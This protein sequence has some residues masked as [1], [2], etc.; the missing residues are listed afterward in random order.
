M[1][2]AG[3]ITSALVPGASAFASEALLHLLASTAAVWLLNLLMGFTDELQC[4][5]DALGIF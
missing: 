5:L 3:A 2:T 4:R 1:F